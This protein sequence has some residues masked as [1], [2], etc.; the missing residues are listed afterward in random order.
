MTY[1]AVALALIVDK[2][3]MRSENIDKNNANYDM[4]YRD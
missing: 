4:T 3:P 1:A 2:K